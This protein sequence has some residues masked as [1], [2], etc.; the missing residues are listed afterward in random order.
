VKGDNAVND[1]ITRW[2]GA[3]LIDEQLAA[4]LQADVEDT[5]T[6]RVRVTAQYFIAA[7][8]AVVLL[9]A[10]GLFLARSWSDIPMPIRTFI[11]GILGGS[12]IAFGVFLERHPRIRPVSYLLETS[13][14][15]VLLMAY[16]HSDNTWD[17]RTLGGVVTGLFSLATPL[18]ATW[19]SLGRNHVM[20]AVNAAIG[21]TFIAIFLD[22]I[23]VDEDAIVWIL[24][25]ILLVVLAV[26]VPKLRMARPETPTILYAFI[27]SMIAGFVLVGLTSIGPLGARGDTVFALDLWL[28]IVIATTIWAIHRAPVWLRRDWYDDL[29]SLCI[30]GAAILA[31][32]TLDQIGFD[33]DWNG[34]GSAVVGAVSLIYGVR[35]GMGSVIVAGCIAIVISVWHFALNQAGSLGAV[36]ALSITAALLFWVSSRLGR[37]RD[38]NGKSARSERA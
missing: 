37:N 20:P 15:F 9:T 1:A 31:F 11:L 18:L 10:S 19:L 16:V 13:G 8:A 2:L 5:A 4:R 27:S 3:G 26:L 14:L 17:A 35:F 36:A 7:T 24:D 12:L 28:A 30:L 23:G 33:R 32:S 21:Y 38:T 6:G 22:R 34:V 29:L 25:A